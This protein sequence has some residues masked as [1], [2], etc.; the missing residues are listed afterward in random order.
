M[1]N[2]RNNQACRLT[3][4]AKYILENLSKTSSKFCLGDKISIIVMGGAVIF[5][6]SFS[7]LFSNFG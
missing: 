6:T 4:P 5:T 3:P 7:Q 2:R 1:V